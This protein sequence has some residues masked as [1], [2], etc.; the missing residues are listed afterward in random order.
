MFDYKKPITWLNGKQ[1]YV[2]CAYFTES[3]V[4]EIT[5]L[6]ESLVKLNL[7]HYLYPHEDLGYWE[8]NTR[9]KPAFVLHCLDKFKEHNIAYTDADSVICQTPELFATIE[10]DLG[11]FKAPA[12]S[13]Y[14]THNY[15]TSTVF[16]KNNKSCRQLIKLWIDEQDVGALQVDQDSFDIAMKKIPELTVYH[17]PFSYVKVFDQ[18]EGVKPVIEHFQASRKRV[19]LRNKV[20]RGRNRLVAS[21][22]VGLVSW[23]IYSY[24]F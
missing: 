23:V 14:F 22:L 8:K 5:Q 1:S 3:Y 16:F 13:A 24:L 19:K 12:E 21:M 17:F 15:L 9:A 4:D 18:Q 10:E 11:V 6:H 2:V 7:N 20:R